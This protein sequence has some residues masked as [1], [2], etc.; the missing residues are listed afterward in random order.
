MRTRY[1]GAAVTDAASVTA[2]AVPSSAAALCRSGRTGKWPAPLRDGRD[3]SG[4]PAAATAATVIA[5]VGWN[6][7]R[8]PGDTASRCLGRRNGGMGGGDG[9]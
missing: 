8:G 6:G 1:T 5:T 7:R 3:Y 4:R 2:R 9:G